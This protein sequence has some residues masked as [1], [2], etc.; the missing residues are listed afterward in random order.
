VSGRPL[1]SPFYLTLS[2]HFQELRTTTKLPGGMTREAAESSAGVS[3]S[4]VVG[5][6]DVE[7]AVE[8]EEESQPREG[9]TISRFLQWPF[10]KE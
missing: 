8:E 9:S 7:A 6:A 1:K 2:A 10:V 4:D 3:T 5:E